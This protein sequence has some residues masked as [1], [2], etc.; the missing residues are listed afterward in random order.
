[1]IRTILLWCVALAC[2]DFDGCDRNTDEETYPASHI[3]LVVPFS[4]GG[5]TDTFART[6]QQ[7]IQDQDLLPV[8]LVIKNIDGAGAT[9]G[10]YTVKEAEPDG[11]TILLLH[12]AIVTAKAYEVVDYGPEEFEPIIGTGE[13]GMVIAVNEE[14]NYHTLNDL[15]N[16]AKETPDELIWTA[17]LG[18]PSHFAGLMLEKRMPGARFRYKQSGGGT[19]R[20]HEVK[21]QHA[22]VT[23][24]SLEEFLRFRAGSLR[25]LAFLGPER[26]P[27]LQKVP[28]AVE[29][30]F[31]VTHQNFFFWWAPKGTDAEC[32]AYLEKVIRTAIESE[33]VREWMESARIDPVI[34]TGDEMHAAIDAMNHGMEGVEPRDM[35]ALPE[36]TTLLLGVV[37]VLGVVVVVQALIPRR[38]PDTGLVSDAASTDKASLETETGQTESGPGEKPQWGLTI[39]V[40][41]AATGYVGLLSLEIAPFAVATAVFVTVVGLLLSKWKPKLIPDVVG[42]AIFMGFGL[43][44]LLT[45]F[46]EIDLP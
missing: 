2:L 16:A 12:E 24:F 45:Q 31:D 7:A 29:R 27:G 36:T 15:M 6:V 11:Y 17:N 18:A 23:A 44:K 9:I 28:T 5:G 42:L 46:F 37:A 32:I 34:L 35:P 8:P 21:G 1:M 13:V 25:G 22:V 40:M 20:F 33:Q 38:K 41:A 4:F 14:S 3:T 43:Q 39:A 26:H 10:S 30:G 19:K